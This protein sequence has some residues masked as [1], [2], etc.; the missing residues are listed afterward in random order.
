MDRELDPRIIRTRRWLS[1][2]LI[3]LSVEKGYD[4]VTIRD[5]TERA[6][7]AYATFYRHYRSKDEL[8]L[9]LLEREVRHLETITTPDIPADQ[10]TRQE[11]ERYFKQSSCAFFQRIHDNNAIYRILLSNPGTYGVVR[12]VKARIRQHIL[13][14]ERHLL[15]YVTGGQIPADA[16]AHHVAASILAL[17]EWWLEQPDPYPPERMAEIYTALIVDPWNG[18]TRYARR[19]RE[20]A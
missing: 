7:V 2:A 8:M 3:N 19:Q 9:H 1:E 15:D 14:L 4:A 18:P 13:H 12:D 11:R 17:I 5:I 20:S 16:L 6:N 10:M